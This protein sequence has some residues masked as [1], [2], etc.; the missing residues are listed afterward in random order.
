M[1]NKKLNMRGKYIYVAKIVNR[2]SVHFKTIGLDGAVR[3][4]SSRAF[5]KQV[6]GHKIINCVLDRGVELVGL[7]IATQYIPIYNNITGTV[8]QVYNEHAIASYIKGLYTRNRL[9]IKSRI[10]K[11]KACIGYMLMDF[12]NELK[13][14][15]REEVIELIKEGYISNA[16]YQNYRGIDVLKGINF[17]LSEMPCVLYNRQFRGFVR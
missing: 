10:V 8:H 17:R 3:V 5:I 7:G 15:S 9:E 4:L 6:E 1:E 2:G 16:T 13:P 12:N 14:Y 11:G